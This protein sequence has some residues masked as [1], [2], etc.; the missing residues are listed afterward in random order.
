MPTAVTPTKSADGAAT[1]CVARQPI[2]DRQDR[3]FGYELLYRAAPG[4]TACTTDGDL[5]GA[6]V[7]TDA[8][9]DIGLDTL[10][11]GRLAFINL[12]RA[13]L[14]GD[15]ST[16]VPAG[17]AVLEIREDVSIDPEVTRKVQEL[18]AAGYRLAL[19]DF[20]PGSDAE[21]LLPFVEFVKLDVLALSEALLE[22]EAQRL[23]ARGLT[24]VAEKVE[25]REMHERLKGMGYHLF[26]GYYFSKPVIHAGAALPAR[27]MAY[28]GL[29]AELNR[30]DLTVGELEALVKQDASLSLRVLQCVNS[31][32]FGIRREVTSIR[33]A[34]VLLG[35]E[36]IRK[37][38]SVWCLAGL[39]TGNSAELAT[40]ALLRARSCEVL[41]EGLT[42]VENSEL[43]IVGLCSLL[44]VM[45]H[46]TMPDALQYLPLS[47][48]AQRALLGDTNRMRSVLDAV[49]AYE[50]GAFEQASS[51]AVRA[52]APASR[53][54]DAYAS[55]LRWARQLSQ[56]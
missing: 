47:S 36:P 55:A 5:A 42:E 8:V 45:L 23:L 16:I 17:G 41:G 18:R 12:T 49:I 51:D 32:A 11:G 19:D 28:L 21:A 33:E 9:L 2:L 24:L 52:G 38:A 37:W 10:T 46:R 26:Q 3:V 43:F 15:G 27:H 53:L 40:L 50:G 14:V 34:L 48:G 7:L 6:R 31:A 1:L 39:N 25:T 35:I 13:L 44:D 56:T 54:P 30:P 29:L 20:V 22:S 4:D